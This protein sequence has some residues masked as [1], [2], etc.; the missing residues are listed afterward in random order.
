MK[1]FTNVFVAVAMMLSLSGN[2]FAQEGGSSKDWN[3]RLGVFTTI[4]GG[5][6]LDLDYKV[7]PEWTVGV[8]GGIFDTDIDS[9]KYEDDIN[10]KGSN[11]GVRAN[12]FYNGVYTDGF[13]IGPALTYIT[14]DVEVKDDFGDKITASGSTM[15]L[16]SL[17]GYGWFW[18][19][20][21][22]MLG[23]GLVL[24]L[25]DKEATL[26]D[27]GTGEEEEVDLTGGFLGEFTVG[28]TF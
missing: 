17:F 4:I 11:F 23:G 7:S 19:N 14:R 16:S 22:M 12:W 27:S 28:W 5:I 2:A 21:N 8:T 26:K 18:E 9:D 6:S 10:V 1:K 3:I 24:P 25:G 20:F 13:Y 15:A